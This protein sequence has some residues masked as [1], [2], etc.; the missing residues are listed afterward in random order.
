MQTVC[1][2]LKPEEE[3]SQTKSLECQLVTLLE[4]VLSSILSP[5]CPDRRQRSADGAGSGEED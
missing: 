3:A 1:S 5:S 2:L 4:L